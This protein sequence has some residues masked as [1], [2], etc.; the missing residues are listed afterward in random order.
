MQ[1]DMM[2]IEKVKGDMRALFLDVVRL[3]AGLPP[4]LTADD[5]S[6]AYQQV[7]YDR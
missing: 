6:P 5:A 1:Q 3:R 4:A 2:S 7:F